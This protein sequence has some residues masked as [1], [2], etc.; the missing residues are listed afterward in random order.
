MNTHALRDAAAGSMQVIRRTWALLTVGLLVDAAFLFVFLI[1][2]QSYLPESL[3][4]SA[5]I[6]GYALAAFGFAKL[7]TQIGG[8][9]VSDR[10]GTRSSMRIGVLLLLVAD[11]SIWPLAHVAPWLILV[12][13]AVEGL[14]S[15]V[16]WPA[17]YSAGSAR[18]PIGQR[19]RFTSLLTLATGG[20]L[21]VGLGGGAILNAR[22]PFDVAMIAPISALAVAATLVLVTIPSV[23]SA[24]AAPS[25]LPPLGHFRAMITSRERLAF[26]LL[27]LA[28]S[29]AVGA[30]TGAF[31]AYGRDVLHVSLY[32]QALMLLP[33]ALVGGALV[34]PGG[35]LADRLGSRKVMTAG[36]TASGIGLLVLSRWSG[37]AVVLPVSAIAG[38]GFGLAMPAI[39]AT[40]MAL[41]GPEGS[42]GGLIGWFMTM[43]GLGHAVGPAVA[44]IMLAT[45]GASSVLLAAGGLFLFVACV[46]L[47]SRVTHAAAAIIEVAAAPSVRLIGGQS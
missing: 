37:A 19:G 22:V 14:G 17:I 25:A 38:G 8:G 21:L 45:L 16:I 40:M 33:A 31:R 30:L 35:A 2:L 11:A 18:V 6:A 34:V 12:S 9:F 5:A 47:V 7:L 20:A 29:A 13:G 43:D 23:P 44:G 10:L 26:A 46:A 41:A 27:V 24:A 36:F 32:H 15:S 28:E 1:A 39:A 4:K 3:H 42:R